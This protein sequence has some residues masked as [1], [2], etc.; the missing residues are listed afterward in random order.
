MIAAIAFIAEQRIREAMER[1]EFDD[2]PMKGQPLRL[3]E[4]ANV[5]DELRMAYKLLKNGGYLDEATLGEVPPSSLDALMRHCP[6]ERVKLRQML[7]LHVVES[8]FGREA[9]RR[10]RLE[11]AEAYR[12][13]V[14]D[15]MPV[16]AKGGMS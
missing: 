9:G 12:D 14:V 16:S 11:A 4:D 5:P 15:R 3:D 1:G 13:K 8:R 10:P 7:K 6:D 2:L